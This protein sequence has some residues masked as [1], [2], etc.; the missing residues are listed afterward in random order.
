MEF[1]ETNDEDIV[2]VEVEDNATSITLST[3]LMSIGGDQVVNFTTTNATDGKYFIVLQY[4]AI[5][6]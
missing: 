4:H 5:Y 6:S 2:Q 1:N 3:I